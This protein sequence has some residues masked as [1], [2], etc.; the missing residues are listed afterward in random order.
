MCNATRAQPSL[1]NLDQL[2]NVKT[3]FIDYPF[4]GI[5]AGVDSRNPQRVS[6]NRDV[7]TNQLL[8]NTTTLWIK[9]INRHE[10]RHDK[11][12]EGDGKN[13]AN[14]AL[15]VHANWM[16]EKRMLFDIIYKGN[17]ESTDELERGACG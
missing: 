5:R 6:W 4:G 9:H 16:S 14:F 12:D 10:H 13:A 1:Y 2:F 11:W 3:F 15:H 17:A 7:S 8:T